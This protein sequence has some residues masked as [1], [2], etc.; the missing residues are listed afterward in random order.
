VFKL[1]VN[2]E[3]NNTNTAEQKNRMFA[4][5]IPLNIFQHKKCLMCTM[6]KRAL[7]STYNYRK[8]YRWPWDANELNG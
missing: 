1:K 6:D 3:N 5:K 4:T 8:H 7:K 2:V